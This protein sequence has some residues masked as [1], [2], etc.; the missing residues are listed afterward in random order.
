MST[1]VHTCARVCRSHTGFLTKWSH[2]F[3]FLWSWMN[4][5]RLALMWEPSKCFIH[6][7][8]GRS[9]VIFFL[10]AQVLSLLQRIQAQSHSLVDSFLWRMVR[11][12]NVMSYNNKNYFLMGLRGKTKFPCFFR[13]RVSSHFDKICSSISSPHLSLATP[14]SPAQLWMPLYR[15][16]CLLFLNRFCADVHSFFIFMCQTTE[17]IKPETESNL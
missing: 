1:H 4:E 6:G 11:R 8:Y 17:F 7:R 12:I 14:K 3:S 15:S 13:R 10:E 16:R 5:D 9:G 2:S